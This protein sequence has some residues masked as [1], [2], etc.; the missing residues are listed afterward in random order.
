MAHPKFL[1]LKARCSDATRG[2]L[3][4]KS[5]DL[6]IGKIPFPDNKKMEY[7]KEGEAFSLSVWNLEGKN[8]ILN[9]YS[10]KG[11]GS[12]QKVSCFRPSP[13]R[14]NGQNLSRKQVVFYG[15][16]SMQPGCKAI[17]LVY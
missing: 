1:S 15:W 4:W 3:N 10:Q 5:R 13:Q 6:V 7:L 9:C 8:I 16:L 2:V 14:L 11:W 12:R 17:G